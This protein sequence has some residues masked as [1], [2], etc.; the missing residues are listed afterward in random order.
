MCAAAVAATPLSTIQPIMTFMPIARAVA[1]VSSA[2]RM[3]PVLAKLDVHAVHTAHQRRKAGGVNAVFID[4]DRYVYA[5]A[6]RTQPLRIAGLDR[7][8][9]ILDVVSFQFAQ[10]ANRIVD[11][12]PLVGV[13][14][15]RAGV[16]RADGGNRLDLL[17]DRPAA[18]FDLENRKVRRFGDLIERRLRI[19]NADGKRGRRREAGVETEQRIERLAECF[20]H[21]VVQRYVEAGARSRGISASSKRCKRNGSLARGR[22]EEKNATTLSTDSP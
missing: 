12:P 3:P 22:Y 21:A 15:Q 17:L 20:A 2:P 19:G 10:D 16:A 4:D 9:A 18:E 1:M 13:D 11:A 8:F 6:Y 14:A 7:L 5:L